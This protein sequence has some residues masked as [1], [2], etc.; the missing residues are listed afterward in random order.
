MMF[1]EEFFRT[2]GKR[3]IIVA[4]EP[5]L[6]MVIQPILYNDEPTVELHVPSNITRDLEDCEHC[7]LCLGDCLDNTEENRIRVLKESAK[8]LRTLAD[9]I[10]A[11]LAGKTPEQFCEEFGIEKEWDDDEDEEEDD[12]DAADE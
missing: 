5:D 11:H 3:A 7:V 9:A 4:G 1:Q 12:D 8:N 10:D 2:F 6:P